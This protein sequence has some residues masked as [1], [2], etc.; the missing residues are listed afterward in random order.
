[1]AALGFMFAA[2]TSNR[3]PKQLA[4]LVSHSSGESR[5]DSRTSIGRRVEIKEP[6]PGRSRV[7]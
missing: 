1:M 4:R 2:S 5:M 7:A 6:D 3:L